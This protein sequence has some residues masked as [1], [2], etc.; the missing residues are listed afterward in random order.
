MPSGGGCGSC[1]D[2]LVA[3]AEPARGWAMCSCFLVLLLSRRLLLTRSWQSCGPDLDG[4]CR[5]TV[6]ST[7]CAEALPFREGSSR[8]RD[9]KLKAGGVHRLSCLALPCPALGEQRDWTTD[10]CPSTCL[11]WARPKGIL[12]GWYRGVEEAEREKDE[13]LENICSVLRISLP[14]AILGHHSATLRNRYA[15]LELREWRLR[16]CGTCLRLQLVPGV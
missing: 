6:T 2:G 8:L 5:V 13:H 12:G 11:P 4:N 7:L 16:T 15:H 1:T 14:S 9:E 10:W 3:E